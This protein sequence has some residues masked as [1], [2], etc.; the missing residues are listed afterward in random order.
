MS[1]KQFVTTKT[2]EAFNAEQLHARHVAEIRALI[3]SGDVNPQEWYDA[4]SEAQGRD[5]TLDDD[6]LVDVIASDDDRESAGAPE[7]M[8]RMMLEAEAKQDNEGETEEEPS[9]ET[10]KSEKKDIS[11]SGQKIEGQKV[12][13]KDIE[14]RMSAI[15]DVLNADNA[16][17][18]AL[19]AEQA[20]MLDAPVVE[21]MGPVRILVR[22]RAM[23]KG[24]NSMPLML[25][26]LPYSVEKT[27][28]KNPV[29]CETMPDGKPNPDIYKAW[30]KNDKGKS[31]SKQQSAYGTLVDD[32]TEGQE[33]KFKRAAIAKAKEGKTDKSKWSQMFL[34]WGQAALDAEDSA[35]QSR[36]TRFITAFR[37]AILMERQ[38]KAFTDLLPNVAAAFCT[39]Q[40]ATKS[41][42]VIVAV[43]K[44]ISITDK[45]DTT[46][47]HTMS[48]T[49]FLS[50]DV[51]KAHD[52]GGSY[53][54][55]KNNTGSKDTPEGEQGTKWDFETFD[56]I[57]PDVLNYMENHQADIRKRLSTKKVEE[58]AMSL[59]TLWALQTEIC[60][61][62]KIYGLDGT[63]D[64]KVRD[65]SRLDQ[66]SRM[67]AKK[68]GDV[69]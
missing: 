3:D 44:P 19:R 16:E 1:T 24:S 59:C 34:G 32:T 46:T 61:V 33:I 20:A 60:N 31:V 56:E 9:E 54:D 11:I 8:V 15:A 10:N 38:F 6:E 13:P 4:F 26:P 45:L 49:S 37:R 47:F 40:G 50:I 5:T 14:D 42:R 2:A 41:D 7:V 67:E 39:V 29:K 65:G 63:E 51:Q 12:R 27:D 21:K 57:I 68:L 55:V 18:N 53:E 35:L 23:F 28:L 58:S 62:L 69:A 22:L 43:M 17:A 48:V 30:R 52:E 36:R 66:A 64:L 25:W